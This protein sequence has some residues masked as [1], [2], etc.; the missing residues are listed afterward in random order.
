MSGL[1]FIC[2]F[3]CKKMNYQHGIIPVQLSASRERERRE[4]REKGRGEQIKEERGKEEKRENEKKEKKR[5]KMEKRLNREQRERKGREERAAVHRRHSVVGGTQIDGSN[6]RRTYPDYLRSFK[7]KT[8]FSEDY[9]G[10]QRDYSYISAVRR[11]RAMS[12]KIQEGG[13]MIQ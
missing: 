11:D 5:R 10:L 9:R 12:L 4:E 7:K 8:S 13:V 1:L 2:P 6:L 3:V